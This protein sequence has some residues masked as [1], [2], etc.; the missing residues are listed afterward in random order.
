MTFRIIC[1][2]A[3]AALTASPS[4]GQT[5]A[6][7]WRAMTRID[8]DGAYDLLK[9]DHPGSAL[10]L[11]DV[12]FVRTL[13]ANYTL[14]KSRAAQVENIEGYGAVL[15][16]FAVGVGD[17]HVGS[18]VNYRADV[19]WA[20]VIIAKKGDAWTV[21]ESDVADL[22]DA[23]IVECDGVS[24][25]RF[26]EEKLGGFRAVWRVGAQRIQAA[27]YLL[28]D[29][30]N[31]FVLKPKTC[32]FERGGVQRV[33]N[34]TWRP[35]SRTDLRTKVLKA[36]P[37]GAAGYGVRPFAGGYWISLEG[38]GG[39]AAEVV[40]V[41]QKQSAQ[42][43]AAPMVV[44]DL[45]GNGGGSSVFGR[46]IAEALVGRPRVNALLRDNESDC[47]TAWRLSARNLKQIDLY[48]TEMRKQIGE[49]F[50]DNLHAQ[51]TAAKAAGQPFSAPVRCDKSREA[52]R[53]AA[54]APSL[55]EGRLIVLTD[56]ICFS[57]CLIVTQDF[58]RLG[59]LH[60]GQATNADTH[61][62][63]VRVDTLPSGLSVFSTLQAFSPSAPKDMG[64]FE[65]A[66]AYFDDIS[67]TK[68]LEA[69]I[70]GLPAA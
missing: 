31:P 40:Q 15:S 62:F 47:N 41:V 10:E 9:T 25:A 36:V 38:L 50:V 18:R 19:N 63:E 11:G 44:L 58:R 29:E 56:H 26:A 69:W 32:T 55:M 33:E 5:A 14:A 24:A 4:T 51:A 8:L 6:E 52:P 17:A 21:A 45:R 48:K 27:P 2:A 61:F 57:S 28:I 3:A 64:P 7:T 54:T 12:E 20:G 22:R 23:V 39:K 42:L 70:A 66:L 65:P 49:E 46:Q 53:S 37:Y 43:H 68:A 35:I 13:E 67:D 34:L 16:G 30:G 59:A 1:M 60:V